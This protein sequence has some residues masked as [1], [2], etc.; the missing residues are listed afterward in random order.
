MKA[1][2]KANNFHASF[3]ESLHYFHVKKVELSMTAA[4]TE[5]WT[6]A[7]SREA[8]GEGMKAS[9]EINSSACTWREAPMEANGTF[10][11]KTV[12]KVL[13]RKP[14]AFMDVLCITPEY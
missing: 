1:P 12:I 2:V 9:T 14:T 10:M 11:R 8:S 6:E 5:P 13:L 4:P 3:R 7:A